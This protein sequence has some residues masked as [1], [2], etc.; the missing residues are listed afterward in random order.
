WEVANDTALCGGLNGSHTGIVDN[1]DDVGGYPELFSDWA[2]VDTDS[3]GIPDFWETENGLDLNNPDDN[4]TILEG[5]T[6]PAIEEYLNNII[7]SNNPF[8]FQPTNLEAE[9]T[10]IKEITLIWVDNSDDE[11]SFL[12][13]RSEGGAFNCIDT[14]P[15]N[16]TLCTDTNIVFDKT[17]MYKIQAINASDS[18]V[19]SNEASASTLGA[20][21]KPKPASEPSP[22]QGAINISTTVNLAWKQGVG[23]KS[24]NV[25]LGTTNPPSFLTNVEETYYTVIELNHNTRYYWRVDEV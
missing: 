21:G 20:D 23:A 22:S 2:L 25:Y 19:F 13:F 5:K 10:E 4:Q 14:L 6:Y 11:S 18:S 15:A 17:Y 7:A 8:M 9:L 24:H 12:L 1:L 16:K 3:D